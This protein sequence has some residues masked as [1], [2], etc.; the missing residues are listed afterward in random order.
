M[1]LKEEMSDTT[2][3]NTRGHAMAQA[4]SCQPLALEAWVHARVS[5]C[6]T[7]TGVSPRSLI[8][9]CH[10]AMAS[11]LMFQFFLTF[12]TCGLHTMCSIH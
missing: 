10:S 6:G 7:W 1:F 3:N 9:P 5:P 12:L 8:F 11:I 2:V 4:D